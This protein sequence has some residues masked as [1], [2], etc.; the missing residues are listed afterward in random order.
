MSSL[1]WLSGVAS[2]AFIVTTLVQSMINVT[3]SSFA[4]PNWQYTLIMLAFLAVTIV[5]NTWGT[6]ILPMLE[7]ISL[8][9][10]I[11]GFI[12]VV[13]ALW[14]LAPRNSAQAVFTEVV[15]NGGWS[16][17]ATSCLVAQV[18]VLYSN[19]GELHTSFLPNLAPLILPQGPIVLCIS[20]SST[21]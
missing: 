4:F 2:G 19:L 15:N 3:N 14:V 5:F 20:V 21:N 11:G 9:G 18:T 8:F 17:T 16:N 6:K 13:V 1:G 10:H 7:T 12:V